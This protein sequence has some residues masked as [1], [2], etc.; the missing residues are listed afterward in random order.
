M[1]WSLSLFPVAYES[2]SLCLSHFIPSASSCSLI[3]CISP[4][5]SHHLRAHHLSLPRPFTPDL[6]L[7]CFTNPFVRSLSISIWTASMDLGLA[8]DLQGTGICF[9][10]FCFGYLCQI[11]L[12]ILSFSV[13]VIHVPYHMTTVRDKNTVTI[14]NIKF[15]FSIVTVFHLVLFI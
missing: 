2:H 1:L 10:I 15:M 6:N 5:H 7:I 4:H 12:T 14:E 8:P 3:L 11:K 13:H 9:Y